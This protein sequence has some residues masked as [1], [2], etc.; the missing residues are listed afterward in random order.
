MQHVVPVSDVGDGAVAELGT[1]LLDDGEDVGKAL[2]GM[3]QIRKAVDH[4]HARAAS[5]LLDRLVRVRPQ[6]D[7]IDHARHDAGDVGDA[8]TPPETHLLRRQ[9]DTV[10]AELRHPHVE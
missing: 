2:A 8:L 6:H 7:N 4:G 10:A 9:I 1:L 3:R 5:E